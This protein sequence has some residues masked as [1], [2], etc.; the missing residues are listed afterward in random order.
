VG[1]ETLRRTDKF[2]H[3]SDGFIPNNFYDYWKNF[4][5]WLGPRRF[6]IEVISNSFLI[7]NLCKHSEAGGI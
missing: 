4:T 6:G 3:L 1:L 2:Y 7:R 5:I